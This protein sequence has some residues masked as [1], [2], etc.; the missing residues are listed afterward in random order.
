LAIHRKSELIRDNAASAPSR[1]RNP[2]NILTAIKKQRP[3]RTGWSDLQDFH[4]TSVV[5]RATKSVS[6]C[7]KFLLDTSFMP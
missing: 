6:T 7:G 1:I 2:S 3:P 4:E 5:F